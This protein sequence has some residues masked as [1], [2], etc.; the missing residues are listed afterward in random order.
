[1]VMR[2]GGLDMSDFNMMMDKA[3]EYL[4]LCED[5]T[6]MST[7][8]LTQQRIDEWARSIF[9]K[10]YGGKYTQEQL[11]DMVMDKKGWN[12]Y[13]TLNYFIDFMSI[14]SASMIISEMWLRFA[15]YVLHRKQW[16]DEKGDW[17]CNT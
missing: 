14:Q 10:R 11:Q 17:I 7:E 13:T 2:E 16:S 5:K 15:M 9:E 6:L 3:Y 1:M 8:P 12:S 4:G